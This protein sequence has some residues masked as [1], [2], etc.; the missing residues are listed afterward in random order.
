MTDGPGA[1]ALALLD[2]V[3]RYAGRT[4]LDGISLAVQPGELVALLGPNGAGKTTAVEILEGYRAPDD[5]RATV[6]GGD[7]RRGGPG[8]R[9]RLG[10]MLQDG[11]LDQRSTPR[12]LLRLYAAFHADARDPE[13]LLAEV[14]L[15]AVAGTRVRRLSGGERQRL[16]LALALVG[17]PEALVLDEPTAG[18]DPE[19]RRT[20]RALIG[21]LRER[22][23]AILMTT[24]DLGD[25]ERLA[26]R[27]A[28]LHHGKVVAEGSPDSIGAGVAPVLRVR[29]ER[30]LEPGE[31]AALGAVVRAA[32]PAATGA[33]VTAEVA[34]NVPA[35]APARGPES[36]PC[37]Y[38]VQGPVA[39]PTLVAAVATWCAEIRIRILE[40]RTSGGSLED[41]YLSLT[42]DRDVE[43]LP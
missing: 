40:L 33:A 37:W 26:D 27:V 7:P 16:A 43:A 20:T 18:M 14:G 38:R 1:P 25:V 5:G 21:D 29:L 11:G 35:E 42:D 3:K 10:H 13:A 4:V 32:V 30:A 22:G 36:G 17:E 6:L 9:A 24:H 8:L 34:T 12:E 31:A 19:A 2:V 41:R 23:L 15:G 39:D 28:I